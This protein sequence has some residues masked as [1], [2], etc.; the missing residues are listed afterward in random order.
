M[1]M[2]TT[3]AAMEELVSHPEYYDKHSFWDFSTAQVGLA[4]QDLKEIAGVMKLFKPA[5]KKFAN[6]A[7]LLV[8]GRMNLAIVNIFIAFST[9]LPF[10]YKAFCEHEEAVEYLES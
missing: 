7:A 5:R 2:E 10:E 3:L 4:I 1:D 6:K 8:A 9:M